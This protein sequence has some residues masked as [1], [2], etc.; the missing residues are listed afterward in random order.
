MLPP[1]LAPRL[2]VYGIEGLLNQAE[3]TPLRAKLLALYRKLAA[4]PAVP[5]SWLPQVEAEL[6]RGNLVRPFPPAPGGIVRAD[7][8]A[9]LKASSSLQSVWAQVA[10]DTEAATA[11]FANQRRTEGLKL[12]DAAVSRAEF[13][14]AAYRTAVAVANAPATAIKGTLDATQHVAFG[15]VGAVLKSPL[16]W[17]AAGVALIVFIGPSKVLRGAISKVK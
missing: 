15:M 8:P 16:A 2:A 5:A 7:I 17:V 6:Q 9:W 12:V 4:V 10:K 3:W 11:A 14:D 1:D 13:W